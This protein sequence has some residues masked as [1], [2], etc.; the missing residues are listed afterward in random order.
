MEF[1]EEGQPMF[2]EFDEGID[3]GGR[4]F[5]S[6][7]KVGRGFKYP[8]IMPLK[9]PS[10]HYHIHLINAEVVFTIMN[11]GCNLERIF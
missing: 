2:D 6:N 7:K 8:M 4:L 9:S 3:G 5:E 11:R 10:S 1:D